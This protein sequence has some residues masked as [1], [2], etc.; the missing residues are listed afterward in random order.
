MG[1]ERKG[2]KGSGWCLGVNVLKF[3]RGYVMVGMISKARACA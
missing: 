1:F 2:V 3:G